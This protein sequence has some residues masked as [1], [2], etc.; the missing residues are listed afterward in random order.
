MRHFFPSF[1][2]ESNYAPNKNHGY[3]GGSYP[4]GNG[5]KLGSRNHYGRMD[6]SRDMDDVE[7]EGVLRG[8]KKDGYHANTNEV[9][10]NA[11]D[12]GAD[13]DHSEKGIWQTKTVTVEYRGNN[14]V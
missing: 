7:L 10:G 11:S 13:D 6:S 3:K 9:R 8:A 2:E 4:S 1:F 5:S 12:A 14:R